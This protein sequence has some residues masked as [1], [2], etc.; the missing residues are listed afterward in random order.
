[1]LSRDV[2]IAVP[3]GRTI[4]GMGQLI[5][6]VSLN[7]PDVGGSRAMQQTYMS[8]HGSGAS[9]TTV[10]VDG[11]MVNGLDVDGAVQ[12]YFNSS[13]SQEMVYTT[14]G[15]SAD[16]SG[17]GVRLNMIPRDG[18]NKLC[19]SVFGGYQTKSFQTDN[20]SQSLKDRGLRSTD[21][22]DQLYNMEASLGGRS[23][24]TRSGSSCRRAPSTS[25]RCRPTFSSRPARRPRPRRRR[26]APSPASIRRKSTARS[27]A[28]LADLAE[29]QVRVLQRSARQ[30]P[31]RRDDRR[32]RPG[33]RVDR[34]E[35][36]DLLD[37][38]GQD[39]LHAE[40]Q[41]PVRR[42]RLV[43]L[44][45]LPQPLPARH[46]EGSPARLS[47]TRPFTRPT[48]PSAR[49]GTPARRKP[50]CTRIALP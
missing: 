42:R 19:G 8:A 36:A 23:R 2:S 34:V 40:Q 22:I 4:Q 1:V 43:Q 7:A 18:G 5:T 50:A 29:A 35:L 39:H 9:Q 31:R 25:T 27:C 3:T 15:A 17:G 45:A 24:R 38:V 6:G 37:R 26:A 30:G 47:G 10:Q 12:N 48:P 46:R 44:R 11:L 33:D 16:V 14:S 41:A 13:M 49:P 32:L 20:L 28:H 21:G